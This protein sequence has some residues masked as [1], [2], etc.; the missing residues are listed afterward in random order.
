[1]KKAGMLLTMLAVCTWPLEGQQELATA[2][3]DAITNARLYPHARALVQH[4]RPG[5]RP[6]TGS[7]TGSAG[8][9]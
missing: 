1:M 7:V 4:E 2:V 3:R 9:L 8:R 6:G 5:G